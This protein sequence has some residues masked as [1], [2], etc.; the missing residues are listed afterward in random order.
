MTIYKLRDF[1]TFVNLIEK[2]VIKLTIKIDIH[3]DEK[4]YG[5]TYDHGC[6]FT[7]EE[8]N[9]YKLYSIIK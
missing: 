3:L 5:K 9:L 6:G 8:H 1:D 4:Y 7:I 2:G